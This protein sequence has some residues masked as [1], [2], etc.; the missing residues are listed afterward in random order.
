MRANLSAIVVGAALAVSACHGKPAA[1]QEGAQT[2]AQAIAWREGD[3]DDALAEAKES[4]K[5]VLLYWG[6]KWCPPCNAMKST[7][8][9]DPAFIAQTRAFVPVYLDGDSKGAQAWGDRFQIAGHPTV[10]ILRA[11]RSEVTR[12]SSGATPTQLADVLRATAAR[13]TSSDQLLRTAL[14][15]P[16]RL[17]PEDW[18]VLA[19][20]EWFN[21]PRHFKDPASAVP[22][23]RRLAAATAAPALARSLRLKVLAARTFGNGKLVLT[24]AEQHELATLLPAILSRYDEVRAGERC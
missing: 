12:L 9:K 4:G 19:S 18:K 3:V 10:I 24:P 5:P 16:A 7:L 23:L 20:Y 6:A 8:F 11:D 22:T 21:D 1:R 14:A 2:P 15:D 17:S 13:V